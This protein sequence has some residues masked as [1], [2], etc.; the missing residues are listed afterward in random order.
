MKN[1]F[2]HLCILACLASFLVVQKNAEANVQYA[3]RNAIEECEKLAKEQKSTSKDE[4]ANPI[5]PK[6]KG[7]ESKKN[8]VKTKESKKEEVSKAKT[9]EVKREPIYVKL[10]LEGVFESARMSE[11]SVNTKSWGELTVLEAKQQGAL[12]SKGEQLIKFD[13]EKIDE[14]ISNLRHDLRILDLD[15]SIAS[16]DLKLAESVA[17]IKL[18]EI[19]RKE[20][21][22]KEDLVRFQK[23]QSPYNKRA[24]AM[25]LKNYEDTLAY[26]QEE[27]KQL[28]KMYEADDLTEETEEIILVRAQSA[29]DRAKFSLEGAKIRNK[30]ALEVNI[31]REDLEA[32][33]KAK[34]DELSYR[35]LRKIQPVELEKKQLELKKLAEQHEKASENLARLEADRKAMTVPSPSSGVAYRGTFEKGKW[36]GDA[37]IKARLRKGGALKPNEV[38]MTIVES[39]PLFVR[40]F[41]PEADLRR[42][43]RGSKGKIKTKAFPDQ[44]LTGSI[45]EVSSA[46]VSPGKFELLLDVSIPKEGK[47]ILPGMSCK[48]QFLVYESEKAI[49]VPANAVFSE[50]K[51]EENKFVYLH[52]EGKKPKKQMVRT[53]ERSGEKIEILEG[54]KPG[55]M[56]LAEKPKN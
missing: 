41:L 17:P 15:R 38:F 14:K 56:I 13:F 6:G 26:A 36:L 50:R 16:A 43:K 30:D 12:V 47:A 18:S 4:P 5:D 9:Y 31:P 42:L 7:I 39:K 1:R 40:A 2:N 54:L 49:A 27:L 3:Q 44:K 45:R 55:K 21:Y 23:I 8:D 22:S 28:K 29:V 20:K 46:P 33:E 37:A 11:V 34:R 35:T 53:G 48:L 10:N 24:A 51:E 32:K 52:R 19:E 25:S